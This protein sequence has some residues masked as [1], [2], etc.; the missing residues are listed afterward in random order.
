M[1]LFGYTYNDSFYGQGNQTLPNIAIV[2][3]KH[4]QDN[5]KVNNKVWKE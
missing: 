5:E 4:H 2:S 1:S 3:D